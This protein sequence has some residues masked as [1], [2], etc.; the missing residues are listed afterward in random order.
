ML[1]ETGQKPE[2]NRAKTKM[3]LPIF[4]IA[5][6]AAQTEVLIFEDNFTNLNLSLWKHELTLS[7]EGN[8]EFEMYVNNRS[9]SY[10]RNGSLVI[11]PKLTNATLGNEGLMSADVNIWGGDPATSC[12][13]NG[14]YGCERTGG[15]GGNVINPIQSARIR[16]AE[17]F[18]FKYG[19]VEVSAKMPK[20]DWLW[21]A[22]WLLPVEAAYGDWPASGE[23]D[24]LESRGN[25]P[26]YV[27]G[28]GCDTF[29]S[30]L[31]WGPFWPLNGY[32]KTHADY[33]LPNGDLSEGFHTYGFSWSP[34]SMTTSIDGVPV[35]TVPINQTFWELG[36]WNSNPTLDNPWQDGGLNA[37]FDQRYYLII[38]LAVG[39]TN[40]FWPDGPGKP[41]QNDAPHAANDFWNAA[42]EWCA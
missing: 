36:G 42:N 2:K 39:G 12:T 9:V 13:N 34:A 22:V 41:W 31:H 40:G 32:E 20:G 33:K 27:G 17:T 37:P 25:A 28:G 15:A 3:R 14:Y 5:F 30:T 29:G 8:W 24:I 7:G 10:V 23:I 18:A 6:A 1:T 4:L 16:T 26:G 21:P 35:L 38:N 11:S 19:R